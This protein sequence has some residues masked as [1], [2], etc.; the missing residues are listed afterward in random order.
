MTSAHPLKRSSILDDTSELIESEP[1]EMASV[2]LAT[3]LFLDLLL[4]EDEG[5]GV[6]AA[7]NE[8][9]ELSEDVV[10]CAIIDVHSGRIVGAS[11]PETARRQRFFEALADT[12]THMFR[13]ASAQRTVDLLREP[14]GNPGG[15]IEELYVSSP[16]GLQFMRRIPRKKLVAVLVTNPSVD[17][18]GGWLLLS[19]AIARV[20][21]ALP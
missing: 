19:Q 13:G 18:A 15:D 8:A 17:R 12:V 9:A 5:A 11:G 6:V 21:K 2:C 1:G 10:A 4:A 3:S 14:F 20:T 7:C 16:W